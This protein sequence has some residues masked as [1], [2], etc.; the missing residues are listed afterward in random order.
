[1]ASKEVDHSY[2]ISINVFSL[3]SLAV[4]FNRYINLSIYI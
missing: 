2:N 4:V 1:M 3:K